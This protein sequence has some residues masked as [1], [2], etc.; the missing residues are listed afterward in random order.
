M[1]RAWLAVKK[2][3]AINKFCTSRDQELSFGIDYSSEIYSHAF[4]HILSCL[5][6]LVN[7]TEKQKQSG[8]LGRYITYMVDRHNF[9]KLKR[10]ATITEHAT[11]AWISRRHHG[12]SILTQD[13]STHDVVNAAIAVQKCIIG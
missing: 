13:M 10:S 11:R 6:F 5:I 8:V 7:H 4:W 12:G 2:K 1:I 3:S 9:V